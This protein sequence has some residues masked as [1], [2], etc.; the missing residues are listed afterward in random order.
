ML[1]L[2]LL[3]LP[4]LL[5][6]LPLLLLLMMLRMLM[7]A[8]KIVFEFLVP[9]VLLELALLRSQRLQ[10][11]LRYVLHR[12]GSLPLLWR[13]GSLTTSTIGSRR[14]VDRVDRALR[15][16]PRVARRWPPMRRRPCDLCARG[17]LVARRLK[18]CQA[19]PHAHPDRAARHRR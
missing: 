16:G 6:L 11:R 13:P 12:G 3:L 8:I 14:D 5:L 4:L 10:R 2:L 19:G 18:P 1:L 9:I 7:V 17:R 15:K